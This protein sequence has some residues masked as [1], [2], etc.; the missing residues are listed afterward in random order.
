MDDTR[1]VVLA[2]TTFASNAAAVGVVKSLLDQRLIA[3]GTLVPGGRSI[4]RWQE[5]VQEDAETVVLFKTA[6]SCVD[7]LK[8]ALVEIHP[9]TTP[10]LLVFDAVD[11][12]PAY[13][14]WVIEQ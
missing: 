10:E 7:R 13:L 5:K 2:V 14:A 3:C 4:Y 1:G 12:L 8:T 9:Y 11:G 6:R